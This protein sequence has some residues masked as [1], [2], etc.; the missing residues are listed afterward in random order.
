MWRQSSVSSGPATDPPSFDLF[1]Q[2]LDA[3][4]AAA[5]G[6]IRQAGDAIQTHR[7]NF[8]NERVAFDSQLQ[9]HV[10]SINSLEAANGAVEK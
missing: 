9:S 8:Q 6:P 5:D 3:S 7:E 1:A 2:T 4:I 10:E